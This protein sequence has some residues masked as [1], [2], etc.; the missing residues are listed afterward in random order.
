MTFLLYG[1]STTRKFVAIENSKKKFPFENI[2]I[3]YLDSKLELFN[4]NDSTYNAYIKGKFNDLD[5]IN[6]RKSFENTFSKNLSSFGT[7]ITRSSELFKTNT[8]ISYDDFMARIKNSKCDAIF[9]LNLRKS[10][11]DKVYLK[12]DRIISENKEPN[13]TFNAYLVDLTSSQPIWL[14]HSEVNGDIFN[15]PNNISKASLAATI[16]R[17]LQ[18]GGYIYKDEVNVYR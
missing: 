3:L 1:C 7:K 5:N 13:A 2:A 14:S 12:S 6:V 18:K 16:K 15:D 4:L 11:D 9:I 8:L 17:K 10:W